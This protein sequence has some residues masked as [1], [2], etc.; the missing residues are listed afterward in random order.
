[1]RLQKIYTRTKNT[2]K[3]YYVMNRRFL[4]TRRNNH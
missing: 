4:S 3:A 2:N 1:M